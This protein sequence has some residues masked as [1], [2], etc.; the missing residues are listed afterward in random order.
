MHGE[1]LLSAAEKESNVVV[2]SA[3]AG[4]FF[5]GG[6]GIRGFRVFCFDGDGEDEEGGDGI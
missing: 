6:L 5:V 1:A 2:C 4:A 3:W